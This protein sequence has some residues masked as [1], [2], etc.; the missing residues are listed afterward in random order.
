M[1]PTSVYDAPFWTYSGNTWNMILRTE[2]GS[3]GGGLYYSWKDIEK[4]GCGWRRLK[5]FC[6][7]IPLNVRTL[8]S[9]TSLYDALSTKDPPSRDK[10]IS[11]ANKRT[12]TELR[13]IAR[14][15][16]TIL[17]L[18]RYPSFWIMMQLPE[19][20]THSGISHT[21]TLAFHTNFFIDTASG[22]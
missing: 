20:H 21:P 4:L 6:D 10:R 15:T 22:C 16:E 12:W 17:A 3:M 18:N 7:F 11:T 1:L 2:L 9:T 19:W 5:L 13:T 14:S 8:F